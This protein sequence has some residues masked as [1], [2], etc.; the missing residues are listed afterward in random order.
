MWSGK[1][2]LHTQIRNL[3]EIENGQVA[4]GNAEQAVTETET[5][6]MAQS[7]TQTISFNTICP[8]SHSLCF[9]LHCLYVWSFWG[10]KATAN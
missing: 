8:L 10:P 6:H 1:A 5:T 4:Q 9:A 3:R 7:L 2:S